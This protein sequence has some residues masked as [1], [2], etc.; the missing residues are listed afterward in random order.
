MPLALLASA[1]PV[2]AAI[3]TFRASGTI[4]R[5]AVD[6]QSLFGGGSLSGLS[7][8]TLIIFDTTVL[9]SSFISTPTETVLLGGFDFGGAIESS[10]LIGG[11]LRV[12]NQRL[13]FGIDGLFHSTDISATRQD[14]DDMLQINLIGGLTGY[15]LR[16]SAAHLFT[17]GPNFSPLTLNP[18]AFPNSIVRFVD[19]FHSPNPTLFALIT[20]NA[21]FV[22]SGVPEPSTWTLM[23]IGFGMIG[24]SMRRTNKQSLAVS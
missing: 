2:Q 10:P 8:E 16:F 23:I 18:V 9:G 1:L 12:G 3:V 11:F 19:S 15:Q 6:G 22:P 4:A 17:N 14:T 24:F 21:Q 7:W 20:S 5:G 13:L